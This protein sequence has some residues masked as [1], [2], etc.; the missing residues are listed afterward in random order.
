[1]L[2]LRLC[3]CFSAL[4][5]AENSST[6]QLEVPLHRPEG[7]SALQRA[8]NSSTTANDPDR[9]TVAEFQCSSASRKFLN[10][11]YIDQI[12]VYAA[13]FSALQRAENSSTVYVLSRRFLFPRFSAL[14]RAENSSTPLSPRNVARSRRVSVLFS[15]P[16]IPQRRVGHLTRFG[17]DVS[18]LFSEPKIPQHSR[19]TR[20]P[21]S[22]RCF[23]ALQRAENSSTTRTLWSSGRRKERF[24]ALQRAENSSTC[25]AGVRAGRAEKFQCSSAS[26]KFLNQRRRPVYV[27]TYPSFSALQRAE[28]SSTARPPPLRAATSGVSVLFSEPKI[29]QQALA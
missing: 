7:F 21:F 4:Q 5:R 16:K 27:V 25:A 17:V 12:S 28:N 3:Q 23:S 2:A 15:E 19:S 22:V 1:M 18:V 26:R 6:V 29:P 20:A 9:P 10:E 8:E 11:E 24:S 14:Q 13:R